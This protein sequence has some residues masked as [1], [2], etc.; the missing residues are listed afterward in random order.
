M[1]DIEMIGA[2]AP[3]ASIVVYF[4]PNTDAGFIDAV[5]TAVNDT[6]H[7]P[8]VVSISWGGPEDTWTA[9]AR[10]QMEQILTDAGGLGVTV[11]AAAGDGGSTDGVSYGQQHVDFPA[12]APHALACGGTALQASGTEITG[13]TVWND[14][15]D[16]AT[17]GGV[18]VEFGPN[19]SCLRSRSHPRGRLNRDQIFELRVDA[20]PAV[21]GVVAAHQRPAA[22]GRQQ[23][24]GLAGHGRQR[25]GHPPQLRQVAPGVD[26]DPTVAARAPQVRLSVAA[27]VSGERPSAD[28]YVPGSDRHYAWAEAID[29]AD[30]DLWYV[31]VSRGPFAAHGGGDGQAHLWRSRGNGWV[32]VDTWGHLAQ[33]RRMPYALATVPGQPGTLLAALRGGTLMRSDDAGDSWSRIDAELEDLIA[34]Q[35]TS[36]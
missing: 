3:A 21:A 26:R 25:I 2:I 18:S 27:A 19:G 23:R 20:R 22:Q 14:T 5:S 33:L 1:L 11:A 24:P 17:G 6:D 32:A 15:G 13:E 16:G 28:R 8:S 10:E 36:G 12:S 4:A 9:Q 31:S 34:I 29:P 35:A 30:P 7:R